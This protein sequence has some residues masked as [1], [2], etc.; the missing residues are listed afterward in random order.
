[1]V[2]DR[3]PVGTQYELMCSIPRSVYLHYRIAMILAQQ[4]WSEINDAFDDFDENVK[5]GLS[6]DF[7][8]INQILFKR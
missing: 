1:M 2:T 6:D 7:I 4:L 5:S 8:I 3:R